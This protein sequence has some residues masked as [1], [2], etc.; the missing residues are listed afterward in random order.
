MFASQAGQVELP[1]TRIWPT[2]TAGMIV[3]FGL[4][5]GMGLWAHFTRISGAVVTQGFVAV[6]T[7]VKSV[8]H[9]EGGIISHIYVKDADRVEAGGLLMRLDTSELNGQIA[10]ITA[11][12]IEA[13]VVRARLEAERF[14]N[15]D[16]DFPAQVSAVSTDPEVQKAIKNQKYIFKSRR[17]N[18]TGQSQVL[19]AKINQVR[20]D[21]E[22]NT[23][24][25]KSKRE[26]IDLV[27]NDLAKLAPLIEKN[28]VTRPRIAQLE[29][30]LM[31]LDG[32]QGR[33]SGDIARNAS[34]IE[35]FKLQ[36]LQIE[37]QFD[38]QVSADFKDVQPRIIELSERLSVLRTKLR[39]AEVRAPI[40]GRVH[41]LQFVTV[42]G[43][44][45]PGR[46]ILQIVPD[47]DRLVIEAKVSPADIEQVIVGN[48]AMVKLS[49][50]EARTTPQLHG[51][52]SVVSPAQTVDQASR[53]IYFN[54]TV[55]VPESELRRLRSNQHLKPG[56]P[57]EVFVSTADRTA[58]EF[59]FRPVWDQLDR[60]LRER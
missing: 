11:Q 56:M 36:I 52:V 51:V 60:G 26:Q 44:I 14:G 46:E 34:A 28:L 19:N 30:D 15:A 24:Q 18:R 40:S 45:P 3:V 21:V 35:E 32:E 38:E 39:L 41:N 48:H 29:R 54:I 16:I 47:R 37:K 2:M 58:L 31:V 6:E 10:S 53:S 42:G 57:T 17:D 13:L 1:N 50:F 8:Q 4:L 27:K 12:H 55:D 25:L 49:A 22:G 43:V 5:G 33:L 59:L 7:K 23:H 20:K 9:L